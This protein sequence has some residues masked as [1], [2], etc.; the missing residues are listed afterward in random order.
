MWLRRFM[1]AHNIDYVN[2][3]YLEGI[4]F[5]QDETTA[6]FLKHLLWF[7]KLQRETQKQIQLS[8]A[9]HR[10]VL[11]VESF[12]FERNTIPKSAC[13]TPVTAQ[14]GYASP[15]QPQYP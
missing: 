11:K 6:V 4:Q 7:L 5:T 9:L 1:K 2:D 15:I 14:F 8:L 13:E 10:R 3:S 12:N